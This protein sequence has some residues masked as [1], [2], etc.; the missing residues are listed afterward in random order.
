LNVQNPSIAVS[1]IQSCI[2][3]CKFIT[4]VFLCQ[5]NN[6]KNCVC[7]W[8]TW[9]WTFTCFPSMVPMQLG[10]FHR[11]QKS[12]T[13]C[14]QVVW[15]GIGVT[16]CFKCFV[17]DLHTS[18]TILCTVECPRRKLSEIVRKL[19]PVTRYVKEMCWN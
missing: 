9:A 5:Q 1:S 16:S 8:K 18:W 13:I 3:N 11:S 15:V 12:F 4:S 6:R 10:K 14:V 17:T 7:N 2:Y 19:S